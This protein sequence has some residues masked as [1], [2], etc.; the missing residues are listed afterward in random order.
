[1]G[2]GGRRQGPLV[3]IN[4]TPMD[5]PGPRVYG[6]CAR[7]LHRPGAFRTGMHPRPHSYGLAVC[8]FC[9]FRKVTCNAF[10]GAAGN[11]KP[12]SNG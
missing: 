1:M 7:P 9:S 3:M 4:R 10:L 2:M 11:D 8:V 6:V 12:N 5:S